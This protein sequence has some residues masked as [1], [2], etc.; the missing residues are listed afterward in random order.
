MKLNEN[1]KDSIWTFVIVTAMIGFFL[2]M[3][4]I[5]V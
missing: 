5:A 3:A 1:T 4:L 2:F